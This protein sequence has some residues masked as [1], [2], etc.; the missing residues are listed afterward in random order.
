MVTSTHIGRRLIAML[1]GAIHVIPREK[2]LRLID[3]IVG[4]A[5]TTVLFGIGKCLTGLY[6]GSST[7]A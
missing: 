7:I 6:L 4:T 1:F 2:N 3:L 5:V